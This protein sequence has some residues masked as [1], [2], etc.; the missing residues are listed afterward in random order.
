MPNRSTDKGEKTVSGR[1]SRNSPAVGASYIT[2]YKG[3]SYRM[4]IVAT[5]R[6]IGYRVSGKTFTSPS[7]AG[8]SVTRH[9]ING[10]KFWNMDVD[11]A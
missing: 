5:R 1:K 6:G 2:T 9:S 7:A 8:K 10:W 3:K 4:E 11:K